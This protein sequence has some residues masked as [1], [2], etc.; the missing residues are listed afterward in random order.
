[1][2]KKHDH[3]PSHGHSDDH[4]HDH[5]HDHSHDFSSSSSGKLFWALVLTS[6]FMVVEVIGGVISGSLALIADAGHMLTDAAALLLAFYAVKISMRPSDEKRSFG[7]GRFQV[8]AA[9]TNGVFLIA[10]T[11]WIVWEAIQ[12]FQNPQPIASMSMLIVAI[13]GLLVN[14]VVFKILHSSS[15]DNINIRSALLHVIGDLLGSVGAII[16]ALVIWQWNILWVDPLLSVFVSLLI[17]K[18]AFRVVKD[19]SHILL[20]GTPRQVDTKE[21][22]EKLQEIEEVT[23]I[24]HIH[25]W[26][27]NDQ[28]KVITLHANINNREKSDEVILQ[29]QQILKSEFT[30]EH[31]TVQI[32]VEDCHHEPCVTATN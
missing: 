19:S 29:I 25:S 12:R 6:T 2:S 10:L 14:L 1:M 16:A 27:L 3:K 23:D 11:A 26:S 18:S 24:H 22:K 28:E 30:I 7:Y 15:E 17:L 9:Y 31:V 4:S 32:E 21:I 8:L 13:L 20:E 5:A